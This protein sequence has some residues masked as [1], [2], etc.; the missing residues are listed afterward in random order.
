MSRNI[1]PEFEEVLYDYTNGFDVIRNVYENTPIALSPD[2]VA[3]AQLRYAI[4]KGFEATW[5]TRFV[6]R[7]YLDNTGNTARS[8]DPFIV[9]DLRL[10]YRP[11]ISGAK[12]VRLS[13]LVNNILN[14]EYSAFGYTYS[15]IFG[16][17]ITENFYYPQATRNFMVQLAVDF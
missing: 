4:F 14:A 10:D 17:T 12:N 11:E 2:V 3:N 16:E 15:Y 1:L 13:L 9:N 8:I 6:G 7:Q 5:L